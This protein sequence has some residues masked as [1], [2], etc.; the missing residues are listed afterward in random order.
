MSHASLNVLALA[1]FASVVVV[2]QDGFAGPGRYEIVNPKTG[3]AME[4][5]ASDLST[6]FSRALAAPTANAGNRSATDDYFYLRNAMTGR[7]LQVKS[8]V[9]VSPVVCAQYS[10]DRDQQWKIDTTKDGHVTFISR[11]GG[12]E[13]D[14]GAG[15]LVQVSEPRTGGNQQFTIHRLGR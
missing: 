8:D 3:N 1:A 7:V 10:G 12:R 14:F 15:S 11:M 13:L 6:V 9:G 4:L 5:N 2:A